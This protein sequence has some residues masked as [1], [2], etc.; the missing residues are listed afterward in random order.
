MARALQMT[1]KIEPKNACSYQDIV[2]YKKRTGF[3]G[4]GELNDQDLQEVI[5]WS[6]QDYS[7]LQQKPI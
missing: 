3:I 2:I 7:A 1:Q 5:F 4:G 6:L